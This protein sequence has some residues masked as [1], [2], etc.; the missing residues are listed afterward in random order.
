M[1]ARFVVRARSIIT[2]AGFSWFGRLANLVSLLVTVPLVRTT[3]DSEL[4]G[5]WM[6]ISSIVGFLGFADF[7]VGNALL[8][9]LAVAR[10]QRDEAKVKEIILAAYACAIGA[11]ALILVAWSIWCQ[12]SIDP[13]AFVGALSEE[14]KIPTLE[15]LHLL[16]VLVAVSFP[17]NLIYKIQQSA[18]QGYWMGATQV[19]LSLAVIAC[20]GYSV[21]NGGRLS[22][23]V[24]SSIGISLLFSLAS[25]LIW[26]TY[27]MPTD[28]PRLSVP[29]LRAISLL[30]KDSGGFFVLQLA[31]AF[32]YQ[33]DGIVVSQLLGAAEYGEYAVVRRLFSFSSMFLSAGLFA[34][35]P[36]FTDALA[37]NQITWLRKTLLRSVIVAAVVSAMASISIASAIWCLPKTWLGVADPSAA[38]IAL[39]AIWS[40]LESLGA[41]AGTF[42]NSAGHL[43]GQLFAAVV[44]ASC[45]FAAKWHLVAILGVE[46]TVLATICAYSLISVPVLVLMLRNVFRDFAY[47]P[48]LSSPDCPPIG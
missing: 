30:L 31:S 14:K 10:S 42:L 28:R 25:T 2:T 18:Q 17:L 37:L 39:L 23:L 3:L 43:R 15:A 22:A 32:A 9:C 34:L 46:G 12:T 35:W 20:T 48:G 45:A 1:I 5:V 33:T 40:L 11:G 6:F 13:T 24:F 26:I 38:L 41:V 19:A 4:F 8:N 27:V 21:Q 47:K 44:M 29:S 36:A 16:F 7:G